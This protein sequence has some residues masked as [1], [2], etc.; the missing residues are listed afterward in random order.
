MFLGG[1]AEVGKVYAANPLQDNIYYY[2]ETYN[3][4]MIDHKLS[5]LERI[6]NGLGARSYEITFNSDERADVRTDAKFKRS[7][8]A[9][10]AIDLT[11]AR[12]KRFERSGTSRGRDPALPSNLV[13]L[14]REPSWQALAESRIEH[15][16]EDF[17]L[18]VTLERDVQI[19][20]KIIADFKILKLDVGA[21]YRKKM[22]FTLTVK[23][24]FG[25]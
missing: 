15:G 18:R 22:N 13:W 9:Q 5:E 20:S 17:R 4:D 21:D 7:A 12:A 24:T 23:G 19:S 11:N 25:G 1:C 8:Q 3:D 14:D 10:A 2:V 16:R 6:L